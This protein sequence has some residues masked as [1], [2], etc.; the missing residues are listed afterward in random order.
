MKQF[1]YL[2]ATI[3]YGGEY[4]SGTRICRL[5]NCVIYEAIAILF[6]INIYDIAVLFK[7]MKMGQFPKIIILFS[8]VYEK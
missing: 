7:D 8:S 2:K 1:K 3:K 5:H 4:E 6:F